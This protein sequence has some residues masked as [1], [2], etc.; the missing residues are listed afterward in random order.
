MNTD[1]V[2]REI[3]RAYAAMNTAKHRLERTVNILQAQ[4]PD[5]VIPIPG[6]AHTLQPY[7][8][9]G[10]LDTPDHQWERGLIKDLMEQEQA[11]LTSLAIFHASLS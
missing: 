11:Y 8:D 1:Q 2:K 9:Q 5:I 3:R 10:W 4:A 7:L 6:S